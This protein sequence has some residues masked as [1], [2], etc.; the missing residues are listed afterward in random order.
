MASGRSGFVD[1]GRVEHGSRRPAR[2]KKKASR[3]E[4]WLFAEK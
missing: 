2:T 1:L 4:H 3:G